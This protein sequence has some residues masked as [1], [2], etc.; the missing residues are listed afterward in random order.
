MHCTLPTNRRPV[1]IALISAA[2]FA[3]STPAAKLLPGAVHPTVLAGPLYCGAGL[4]VAIL[5]RVA[6]W[7]G[8]PTAVETSLGSADVRWLADAAAAG[9]IAGPLLPM[10]GLSQTDASAASLLLTLEGV[11]AAFLAHLR[12][13]ERASPGGSTTI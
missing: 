10:F 3:V 4:C 12:S 9:G 5:R 8:T 6:R 7:L 1:F 13:W 2:H 11:A